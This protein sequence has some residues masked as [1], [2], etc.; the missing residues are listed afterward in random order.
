MPRKL[1][2]EEIKLT[3][4]ERQR[5]GD[6]LPKE[7]RAIAAFREKFAV[8]AEERASDAPQNSVIL[9]MGAFIRNDPVVRMD[10]T[11]AIEQSRKAGFT[12]GYSTIDEFLV[13]LDAMMTYAPPF[14]ESSLIHCPINAL[15]DW[16]MVMPSGY[17]LFRDPAFKTGRRRFVCDL[18]AV[19]S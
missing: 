4:N 19:R 1:F 17:A 16:P 13:L 5:L 2:E 9:D 8:Y 11:R 3:S 7:E 14:S 18:P 15:L 12:L 6:W 10:F